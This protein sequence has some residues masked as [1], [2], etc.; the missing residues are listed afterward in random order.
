[1]HKLIYIILSCC[2][3]YRCAN[4]E[5]LNVLA[6]LPYEGKSHFYVFE[7]YLRELSQ[8]G[9]NVT[10]ISHFPQKAPIKNYHDISLAGALKVL[11]SHFTMQKSYLTV[12]G[13]VPFLFGR[14]NENCRVLL[15]NKK[16][17]EL[18][19]SDIKFDVVVYEMF[20]SDCAL[21]LAHQFHAPVVAIT[22]HALLPMHYERFGIPS[23]PSYVPLIFF[24][25]GFNPSLYQRVERTIFMYYFN[26]IYK[27]HAQR[28]D[29]KIIAE[30]FDNVPP[31][32][33]LAKDVKCALVYHNFPL[34]GSRL[35]PANI[36]EVGGYHVAKA[37]PLPEVNKDFFLWN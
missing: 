36:I 35:F 13:M 9:H 33:S 15:E 6:I 19:K 32:E 10:V 12:F 4:S 23:N 3:F 5:K 16:V 1:M 27:Y 14:G 18:W 25:G 28:N 24:E 29:D 7:P 37:K 26:L 11:E 17:Q 21:G 34:T 22:S 20:N 2:I 31:V 30:Y 8:R